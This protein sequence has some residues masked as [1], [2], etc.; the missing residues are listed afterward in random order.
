[1]NIFDFKIVK[2]PNGKY[3]AWDSDAVW[4]THTNYDTPEKLKEDLKAEILER[5]DKVL[6]ESIY[7]ADNSD[8]F[9][10]FVE[11][12]KIKYG[13]VDDE[14]EEARSNLL[15]MGVSVEGS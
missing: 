8:R 12:F 13:L 9:E 15:E 11:E 4:F 2:Q 10:M 3:A 5:A 7:Y 14:K 1:M 6:T